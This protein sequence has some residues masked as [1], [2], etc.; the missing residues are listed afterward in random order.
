MYAVIDAC[1]RQY[2]VAEGDL[3]F[4]E[5]LEANENEKVTFDQVLLISDDGKVK[6]GNPTIKG[7]KVEATVV[8]QGKAKKI[9]VFKYKAKKNERKKQ[10]H[11][12]PYTQVKIEKISSR[13]SSKKEEDAE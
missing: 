4:V 1:G 10:G 12:Q 11:R 8:K 9:V 2:K 7:A 5:K 13:A 3:V 6:V